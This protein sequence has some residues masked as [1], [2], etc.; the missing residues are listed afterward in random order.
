MRILLVE[1]HPDIAEAIERG[2][3]ENGHVC[4]WAADGYFA[5]ELIEES[6]FDLAIIDLGLPGITGLELINNIRSR[7]MQ[8]GIIVVSGQRDQD[9]VIEALMA[10]ADDFMGKPFSFEE[11]FARLHAVARRASNPIK[12][13]HRLDVESVSFDFETRNV[14]VEGNAVN[15]RE[16]EFMV[17]SVLASRLNR[18]VTR[19]VLAERVWGSALS[20][21]DDAINVTVSSLRQQLQQSR[22][23][24]LEVKTVRGVGYVLAPGSKKQMSMVAT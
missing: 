2:L 13:R 23:C 22:G 17:L 1:D 9:S 19:T 20:V 8:M 10:G 3:Q 11:L 4:K 15:L 6:D 5:L 18:V 16:K 7:G 14:Y 24:D 12:D 21:S